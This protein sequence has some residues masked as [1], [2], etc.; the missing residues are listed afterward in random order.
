MKP[1]LVLLPKAATI[2]DIAAMFRALVGRDPTPAERAEAERRLAAAG[3]PR[4][5][6]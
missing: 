2:D 5:E 6:P 4:Q 3:A 1:E